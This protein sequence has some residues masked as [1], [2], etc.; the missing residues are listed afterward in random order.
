[1][2]DVSNLKEDRN[3]LDILFQEILSWGMELSLSIMEEKFSGQTI[4]NVDD[5]SL[6]AC[7]SDEMSNELIRYIAEK[8]PLRA[9][10]MDSSFANSSD[11]IN[12]SQVFKEVSPSTKVKVV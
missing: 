8:E 7:F 3:E 6:I 2:D 5:N 1:M 11:K 4:Y 12:I 9:I 10:F